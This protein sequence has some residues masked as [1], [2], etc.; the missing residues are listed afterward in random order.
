MNKDKIQQ[1]LEVDFK[2]L[3]VNMHIFLYSNLPVGK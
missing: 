2:V 1:S 3:I